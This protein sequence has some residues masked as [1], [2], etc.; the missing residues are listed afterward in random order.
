MRGG[1][2]IGLICGPY[3][4]VCVPAFGILGATSGGYLGN[5]V[6]NEWFDDEINTL[7]KEY[8]LD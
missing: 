3:A 2:W 7:L 8:N 6:V 4:F 1:A 5:R